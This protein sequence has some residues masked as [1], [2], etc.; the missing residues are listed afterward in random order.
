MAD[1]IVLTFD[2]THGAQGAMAA[3]RDLTE[4]DKAWVDDIAV[5]ERH[6]SGRISTHTT[7]GSVT[8]G[9][10]FGGL[11]GMLIGLLFPPFGFLAMLAVGAGAGALT[12]R[13][14]KETG[15]DKDMLQEI[16]DALEK[17]TSAL[18]MIGAEGD[19]D[20]MA[21]AFDAYGPT[22]T[23]RRPLADKTVDG[24]REGMEQGQGGDGKPGEADGDAE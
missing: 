7:H 1:L 9:A 8:A 22:S 21:H 10:Y 17:G 4:L 14:I 2:E 13:L 18:L 11:T 24:L 15:L 16:K 23:I 3:V 12:Q 20:E 6:R 19:V 5:V